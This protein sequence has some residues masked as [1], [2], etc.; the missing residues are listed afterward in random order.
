MTA[1]FVLF[2]DPTDGPRAQ[3][4][5]SLLSDAAGDRLRVR[6]AGT[7]PAGS[8]EG[9]AEVLAEVGI[10]FVAGHTSLTDFLD[11]PPDL[12]IAVCEEGCPSCPYVPGARAV[13]RWPLEDPDMLTGLARLEEL[14]AIR[15]ALGPRIEMLADEL[16]R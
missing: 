12:L 13:R 15:D 14:R 3:L 11:G 9:V 2:V 1:P 5:R 10:R 16:M 6:S 4:A 7:R 8:L